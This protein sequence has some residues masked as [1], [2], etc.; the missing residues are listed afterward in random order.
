VT[1]RLL[2]DVLDDDTRRITSSAIAIM[3]R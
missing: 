2:D 1:L 3:P